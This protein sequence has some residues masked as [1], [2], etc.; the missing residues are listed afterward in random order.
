MRRSVTSSENGS[1]EVSSLW[2]ELP[3][4]S[5]EASAVG[6]LGVSLLLEEDWVAVAGMGSEIVMQGL[7][8]GPRF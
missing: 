2:I 5:A 4:C 1:V 3:I 7:G 8:L 6:R